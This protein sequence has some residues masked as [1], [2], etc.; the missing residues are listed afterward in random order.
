MPNVRNMEERFRSHLARVSGKAL[1]KEY[2]RAA[3]IR[4]AYIANAG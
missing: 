2:E 3:P 1:A 4:L